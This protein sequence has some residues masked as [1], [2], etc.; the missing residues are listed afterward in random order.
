MTSMT[1]STASKKPTLSETLLGFLPRR[2]A[3]ALRKLEQ[4]VRRKR[5][6]RPHKHY[7]RGPGPKS[8]SK[9]T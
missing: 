4:G 3:M 2:W 8:R 7:M 5:P 9:R 1:S 6:Y